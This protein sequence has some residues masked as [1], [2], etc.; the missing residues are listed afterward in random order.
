LY[1]SKKKRGGPCGKGKNIGKKK[2]TH[3]EATKQDGWG[4]SSF[5][6]LGKA[7]QKNGPKIAQK[8]KKNHARHGKIKKPVVLN[9]SRTSGTIRGKME[10]ERSYK[11]GGGGSGKKNQKEAWGAM[12]R[13]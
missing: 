13:K 9:Q 2:K 4:R 7:S 5:D 3:R 6:A 8:G 12:G 10:G 11:K 1:S